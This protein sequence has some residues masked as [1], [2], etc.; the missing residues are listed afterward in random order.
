MNELQLIQSKIYEIRGQKVM[1]DRDL[2]ELYNVTTSNLNKAVKRNI[3][4]FP[5]DFMFQ[6]TKAEFDELKTNLIFQNGTS[7]WGGTRKL[8]YAF[9]EQGLAMLSGLLNSDI[10]IKVNIN[11]MRAFVAI[12]QMITD[13]SPLKRLSTLEKNFNELKQDLEKIFADYN[14]INED[15]RAQIEAIN[16]TLAELQAKPKNTPRSPVGFIKPKE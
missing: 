4:R 7:N 14:D 12:R 10:A 3:R 16:T 11:I 13:N 15:T 6:L 5:D 8:P 1:L 2:A 9:T